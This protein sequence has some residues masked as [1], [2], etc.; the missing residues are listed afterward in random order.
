MVSILLLRVKI[1]YPQIYLDDKKI[2]AMF[3]KT[4]GCTIS[5]LKFIGNY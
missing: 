5:L 2:E 1:T 4:S 3:S